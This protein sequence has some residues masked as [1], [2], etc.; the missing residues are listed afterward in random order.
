[1]SFYISQKKTQH[2]FKGQSCLN[3]GSFIRSHTKIYIKE[4]FWI[5]GWDYNH[6]PKVI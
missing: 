5:L 2:N 3:L 6:Y 4:K 1:M